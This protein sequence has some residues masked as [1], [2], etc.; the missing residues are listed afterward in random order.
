MKLRCHH[1][2]RLAGFALLAAIAFAIDAGA[3]P[4]GE[5]SNRDALAL[6]EADDGVLFVDVRTPREYA[7]GH[8]PSAVNIPRDQLEVRLAALGAAGDRLVVYCERGPRAVAAIAT[9][10]RAGYTGVRRMTGDMSGWRAAG[11]PIEK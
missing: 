8:V 6:L 1:G 3:N 4:S 2:S 9:L 7:S 11:L 5:I 10:V